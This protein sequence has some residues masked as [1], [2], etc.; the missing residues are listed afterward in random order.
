MAVISKRKTEKLALALV[1]QLLLDDGNRILIPRG[2]LKFLFLLFHSG[3]SGIEENG[4]NKSQ[5][6]KTEISLTLS[7]KFEVPE[8]DQ[9]NVIALMLR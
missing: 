9:S 4:G 7:N 5:L 1:S 8:D 2:N 3:D 6:A